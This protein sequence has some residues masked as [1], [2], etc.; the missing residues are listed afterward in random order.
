MTTKSENIGAADLYK[1]GVLSARKYKDA[2]KASEQMMREF[3]SYL[4]KMIPIIKEKNAFSFVDNGFPQKIRNH[5]SWLEEF[6]R[7]E[8]QH[9]LDTE[10]PE[11]FITRMYQEISRTKQP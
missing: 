6:V 8:Y 7:D 11:A 4:E 3:A 5:L 9:Q 10:S 1:L 2:V